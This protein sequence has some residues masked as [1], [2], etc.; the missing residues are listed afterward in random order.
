M[1]VPAMA[2]AQSSRCRDPLERL[3]IGTTPSG[4]LRA[5]NFFR[6]R[7]DRATRSVQ[8]VIVIQIG[9]ACFLLALVASILPETTSISILV[10]G[11]FLFV[12]SGA[13]FSYVKKKNITRRVISMTLNPI[14][15]FWSVSHICF[16][17]LFTINYGFMLFRN[18]ILWPSS[19]ENYN[20]C[21]FMVQVI[22]GYNWNNIYEI[23]RSSSGGFASDCQVLYLTQRFIIL[24]I[25]NSALW[26][27]F[28]M[29]YIISPCFS[30]IWKQCIYFSKYHQRVFSVNHSID[31]C[32]RRP[33]SCIFVFYLLYYIIFDSQ[34]DLMLSAS[35]V[36]EHFSP[37]VERR[38]LLNSL[39]YMF[40][41]SAAF[42]VVSL[43]ITC[44]Q[45]VISRILVMTFN[46][47]S[48]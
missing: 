16:G 14:I 2:D 3:V 11:I 23:F 47:I 22:D 33:L 42:V 6:S 40:G 28:F 1:K 7:M 30:E 31:I 36:Y 10:S 15:I 12:M 45:Q 19:P 25:S 44:F 18:E 5:T 26:L 43:S 41:S 8:R 20:S 21:G 35:G 39:V 9:C 17:M 4:R 24:F 32:H 37:R 48:R 46:K 27:I 29:L 13:I 38:F 34:V